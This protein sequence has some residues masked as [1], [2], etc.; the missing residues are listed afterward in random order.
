MSNV[1]F[2]DSVVDVEKKCL[3]FFYSCCQFSNISAV[4][5][6]RKVYFQLAR[7]RDHFYLLLQSIQSQTDTK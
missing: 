5:K 6:G 4:N 7:F 3:G 1:G 2:A